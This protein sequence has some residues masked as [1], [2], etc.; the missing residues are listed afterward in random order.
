MLRRLDYYLDEYRATEFADVINSMT[1]WQRSQ[2]ARAG[3]P[4]LAHKVTIEVLPYALK[5]RS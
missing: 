2:W 3:Y 1:N 4:G 5:Q